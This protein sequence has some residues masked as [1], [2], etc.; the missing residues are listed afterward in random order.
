MY[1]NH[2]VSALEM[3]K[4]FTRHSEGKPVASSQEI[5]DADLNIKSRR[6]ISMILKSKSIKEVPLPIGV[7]VK[8][9]QRPKKGKRGQWSIPKKVLSLGYYG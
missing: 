8:G 2:T 4:G 9:F 6:K 3:A 5:L 7:S 1:G